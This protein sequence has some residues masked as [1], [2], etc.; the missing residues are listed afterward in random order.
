M[1]CVFTIIICC[2]GCLTD[3]G[4]RIGGCIKSCYYACIYKKATIVPFPIATEILC[5][6]PIDAVARPLPTLDVVVVWE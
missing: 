5:P 6:T 2:R 1:I 4:K 3:Y